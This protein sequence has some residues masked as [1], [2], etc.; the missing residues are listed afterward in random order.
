[1]EHAKLLKLKVEKTSSEFPLTPAD[2]SAL[3]EFDII[4]VVIFLISDRPVGS[5]PWRDGSFRARKETTLPPAGW[6]WLGYFTPKKSSKKSLITAFETVS[7]WAYKT[8]TL[9]YNCI[10]N[11][12][13]NNQKTI[14]NRPE[15]RLNKGEQKLDH[16]QP[17]LRFTTQIT[18]KT[19]K[20]SVSK[21]T[22]LQVKPKLRVSRRQPPKW[23]KEAAA[24]R[25]ETNNIASEVEAESK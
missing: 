19:N 13:S 17:W 14:T 9:K 24:R 3:S 15:K 22:T 10:K 6:V 1:M 25:S 20:C 8:I 12:S 7:T 23:D 18:T 5:I 11:L 16:T 21:Q 4:D 2:V